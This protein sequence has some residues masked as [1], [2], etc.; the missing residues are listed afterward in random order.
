VTKKLIKHKAEWYCNEE[1]YSKGKNIIRNSGDSAKTASNKWLR[2]REKIWH[3]MT[4]CFGKIWLYV[5]CVYDFGI[6]KY[7]ARCRQYFSV[8]FLKHTK[9]YSDIFKGPIKF[10]GMQVYFRYT[11]QPEAQDFFRSYSTFMTSY[12]LIFPSPFLI[13]FSLFLSSLTA[14]A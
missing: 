13:F 14:K 11:W 12:G 7:Q 6:N 4:W 8:K 2:L 10:L 5:Y 3:W 9:N 1:L